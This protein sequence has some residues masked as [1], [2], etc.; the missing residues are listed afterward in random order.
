MHARFASPAR[1]G[2]F[3]C[4]LAL[5][6]VT[7]GCTAEASEMRTLELDDE[8]LAYADQSESGQ[9]QSAPWNGRPWLSL[10]ANMAL[11][12]AHPLGRTP[13]VVLPY[14]SF[15]QD[16]DGRTSSATLAAGTVAEIV[17]VDDEFVTVE[18]RTQADFYLRVVLH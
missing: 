12:I 6:A 17:D 11:R 10:K 2:L 15:S 4:A 8:G 18:N 7:H 9:W 1:H 3:A 14:I 13:A 5:L 16:A